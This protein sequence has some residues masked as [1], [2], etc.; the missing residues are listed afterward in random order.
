[1]GAAAAV[2]AV[3]MGMRLVRAARAA[4]VRC[5][6][7]VLLDRETACLQL[8]HDVFQPHSFDRHSLGH[9]HDATHDVQDHRIRDFLE[10]DFRHGLLKFRKLLDKLRHRFIK[11]QF[12]FHI[13]LSCSKSE[14][15]SHCCHYSR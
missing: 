15:V 4:R 3:H 5:S 10:A 6:S 11:V 8:A 13:D 7:F 9:G 14:C 2:F 1:M 12:L